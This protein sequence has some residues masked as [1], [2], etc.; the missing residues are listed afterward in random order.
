MDLLENQTAAESVDI[1]FQ[2]LE[3]ILMRNI[4]RHCQDYDQP[5]AT[6]IWLL[7]KLAEIG[8]LDQENIKRVTDQDM[9]GRRLLELIHNDI[10][11]YAMHTN[12]D[13][14]GMADLAARLMGLT[15]CAVLEEVKDGE[16]IGRVGK[17]PHPMTLRECGEQVKV[18]Y[19]IPNVRLFGDPDTQVSLVG[20]CPGAGKSTMPLALGFGCD[21]YITGDIDHHTGIDAVDQGMCIIDAGHYGVEHIF[22]ED[23]KAY[24]ENVLTG[25]H[26]DCVAVK[27]PFV[28]I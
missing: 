17:L 26:M 14:R 12:Y 3:A 19:G 21:V 9:N 10:S 11:Y 16:G 24:L 2:D 4:I 1:V 28:V 23:V 5:I 13:T 20:I 15:E 7:Q 18:A 8:R 27:H 22:M 25:V 6:D